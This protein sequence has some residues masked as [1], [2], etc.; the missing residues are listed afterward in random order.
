MRE[1]GPD[2]AWAA[3]LDLFV[4]AMKAALDNA[5]Q[6]GDS[7][8]AR[9]IAHVLPVDLRAHFLRLLPLALVLVFG[10]SFC[11]GSSAHRR[12][13]QVATRGEDYVR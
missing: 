9:Q 10:G 5:E 4:E 7:S 12:K 11:G 2:P 1:R 3:L 13:E 6:L 8:R